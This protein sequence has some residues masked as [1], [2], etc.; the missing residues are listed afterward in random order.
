MK[1]SLSKSIGQA[2]LTFEELE[3]TLIDVEVFMNNRP[4]SY[5]GEECENPV[6]TPNVLLK[7]VPAKFL[8]EDLENLNYLDE[9]TVAT[10]RI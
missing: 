8:E 5:I 9:R 6:L 10:Q 2:L 3:E 7:G 4:L 1:Q